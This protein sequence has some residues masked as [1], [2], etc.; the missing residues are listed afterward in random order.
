VKVSA[1]TI[2]II[3][4]VLVQGSE[5][6]RSSIEPPPTQGQ[7]IRGVQTSGIS[8]KILSTLIPNLIRKDS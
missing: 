4:K 6:P 5:S 2:E 7:P 3:V 1:L 8:M